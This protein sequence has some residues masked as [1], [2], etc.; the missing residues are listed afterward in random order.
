MGRLYSPKEFQDHTGAIKESQSCLRVDPRDVNV[1]YGEA[2]E[3]PYYKPV[4]FSRCVPVKGS[5]FIQGSLL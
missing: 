4:F 1:Y 2:D 3:L 5:D